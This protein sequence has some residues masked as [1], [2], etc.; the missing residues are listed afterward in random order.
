MG[1]SEEGREGI[2]REE[3]DTPLQARP[4]IWSR[5]TH[6]GSVMTPGLFLLSSKNFKPASLVAAP[7]WHKNNAAHKKTKRTWQGQST[8]ARTLKQCDIKG[9][10]T[11]FGIYAQHELVALAHVA[12]LCTCKVESCASGMR[13]APWD[14]SGPWAD[15]ADKCAHHEM[16]DVAEPPAGK[17]EDARSLPI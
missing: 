16:C 8:W 2:G 14:H 6:D 17:S 7:S 10:S 13:L 15:T 1:C 4:C 3:R 9:A 11:K 12:I 5:I